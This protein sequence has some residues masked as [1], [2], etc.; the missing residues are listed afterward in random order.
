MVEDASAA[1]DADQAMEELDDA[2]RAART[3]GSA[4]EVDWRERE[5]RLE[6][7]LNVD[8][9]VGA[10]DQPLFVLT[11]LLNLPDDLAAEDFPGEA[12]EKLQEDLRGRIAG[13]PVDGWDWIVTTRTKA[14]ADRR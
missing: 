10:E 9:V 8:L 12:V 14:G 7:N 13:T 3:V 1:H 11:L 5:T 6:P 4:F 2:L